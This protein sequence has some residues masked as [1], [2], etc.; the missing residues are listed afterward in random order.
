MERVNAVY[1]LYPRAIMGCALGVIWG[2]GGQI[3]QF[4]K[5]GGG[6][7]HSM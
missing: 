3:V 5:G 1:I 7:R 6:G 4:L 2:G